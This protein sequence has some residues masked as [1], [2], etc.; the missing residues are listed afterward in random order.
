MIIFGG[1]SGIIMREYMNGVYSYDFIDNSWECLE[2]KGDVPCGRSFHS[3]VIHQNTL[4]IFGGW[5]MT[6]KSSKRKEYYSNE[7]FQFNLE[8]KTWSQIPVSGNPPGPRNRHSCVM[9]NINAKDVLIFFGGNY[10]DQ[11][12]RKGYFYNT[13]YMLELIRDEQL[14][15]GL[16]FDVPVQGAPQISHHH[17]VWENGKMYIGM[18]EAKRIKYNT[19][20]VADLINL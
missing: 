4:I 1:G 19:T 15:R 2:V 3:A 13:A 20:Y 16:W 11:K 17:A 6:E 9:L 5:W 7:L 12:S 18:G 14:F 8:I 10:Y